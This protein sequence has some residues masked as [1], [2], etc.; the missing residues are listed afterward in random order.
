MPIIVSLVEDNHRMRESFAE[1]LNRA[2][3][4]KCVSAYASAEEAVERMPAQ[5]PD[6]AV[7]DIHLPGMDG[8][9][10]VTKL[11]KLLPTL[12]I[13]MLT[14]YEQSDM[15][16]NS[17][18]AGASGYLLK[19]APPDELVKAIELVH[20]GGAP[21]SMQVARKVVTHF[22]KIESPGSDV[23]RLTPREQEL[24]ELLAKGYSYKELSDNLGITMN[25]VRTHLQHIYEKLHVQS[26]TQAVL[27]FLGR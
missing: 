2:P 17:I 20:A 3:G 7:V 24:L 5:K 16:F 4:I 13:L 6:V 23:E 27:K 22:R 18:C 14:R 8:I 15:V 25:T 26:R 9:A 10:C 19:S 12:R 11:K 1:V 21:M